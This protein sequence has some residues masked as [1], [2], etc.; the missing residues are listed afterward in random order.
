MKASAYPSDRPVHRRTDEVGREF[1]EWVRTGKAD[2]MERRHRRLAELML[3]RVELSADSRVLDIGCGDGWTAR[4]LADRTQ[5]GA[6][7]G[8]DVSAEMVR[9]ARR[10]CESID[11]ALFAPAPA[12]EVPWAE[13]Y[14]THILS[15]ESAYYWIDLASAVR[16]MYRVAA[17]GG[18][19]HVLINYY[20]ENPYSEGWDSETG[21]PMHRLSADQWSEV[22]R[23]QGFSDVETDRIPDDSPVS[24]FKRP[25]ERKRR[26]GLQRTG[27]LYVTG[28]KADLPQA[29]NALRRPSPNPFRILG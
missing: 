16:E 13:D 28:R 14:F 29:S 24:P 25:A 26:I 3:Q 11:H 20:E 2:G 1:D 15:I 19:F 12:E 23:V 8:I 7:V 5:G 10:R 22:F 18:S 17:Y 4:M 21:L 27:A 9:T 6:L